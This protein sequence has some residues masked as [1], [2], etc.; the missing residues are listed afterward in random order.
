MNL[1]FENWRKYLTE[2]QEG[3]FAERNVQK[4]F[5]DET[6]NMRGLTS[7]DVIARQLYFRFPRLKGEEETVFY[8]WMEDLLEKLF[9]QIPPLKAYAVDKVIGLGTKGVAFLMSSG[10]IVKI[11]F[12][13]Y[14][15]T[16]NDA[17]RVERV[18]EIG[19]EEMKFYDKEQESFFSGE[20]D[21]NAL[22]I[23]SKGSVSAEAMP[24]QFR[25][26]TKVSM[27][28]VEMI[29]LVSFNSFLE[30]ERRSVEEIE[31]SIHNI[32]AASTRGEEYTY[33]DYLLDQEDA[34]VE[35][36]KITSLTQGEF[37]AINKMIDNTIKKYG[38][39]YLS[40]LHTAN[41]GI[42]LNTIGDNE[43]TFVLFDP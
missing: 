26:D 27:N 32:V 36:D 5:F 12:S 7:Y 3:S 23:I 9:E 16:R 22:Y 11:F 41:F 34:G 10:R 40:D 35:T 2:Q 6:E 15:P 30:S 1:L 17:G 20:G 31:E 43:P 42:T 38:K 24:S 33:E 29:R 21:P 4:M 18:G 13:G 28:Y 19:D 8:Y 37:N 39:D 14:L 25:K